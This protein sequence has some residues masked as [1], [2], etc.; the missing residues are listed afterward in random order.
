MR[1]FCELLLAVKTEFNSFEHEVEAFETV[2]SDLSVLQ[3]VVSTSARVEGLANGVKGILESIDSVSR[4][5]LHTKVPYSKPLQRS[6]DQLPDVFADPSTLPRNFSL[7][8]P[9]VK[10]LTNRERLDLI[11]ELKKQ[12]PT[13]GE[14]WFLIPLSW[15]QDWERHCEQN[16]DD[17]DAVFRCLDT[18]S[19]GKIAI[20]PDAKAV[21][22]VA[23]H[24]PDGSSRDT[25]ISYAT[26]SRLSDW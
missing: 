19:V 24:W 11:R 3:K 4:F 7:A 5:H 6:V 20:C 14:I 8:E 23:Q 25:L 26:W 21:E 12:P 9:T 18:A 1:Q 10:T 15:L 2:G 16:P 22:P 17:I 13:N